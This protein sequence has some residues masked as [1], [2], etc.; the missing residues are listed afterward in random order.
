MFHGKAY[1]FENVDYFFEKDVFQQQGQHK[2][3]RKH[4]IA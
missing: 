1:E 4:R 3:I 2:V